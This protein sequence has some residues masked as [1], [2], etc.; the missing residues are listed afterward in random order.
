MEIIKPNSI[1]IIMQE[2][3]DQSQ[4]YAVFYEAN[5]CSRSTIRTIVFILV[6]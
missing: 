6:F 1:G 4:F 5:P 2:N 3:T